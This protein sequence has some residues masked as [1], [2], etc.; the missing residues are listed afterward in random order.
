[1]RV[2]ASCIHE[3]N[4]K[5]QG[6]VMKKTNLIEPWLHI[7]LRVVY[8]WVGG[9]LEKT[10]CIKKLHCWIWKQEKVIRYFMNSESSIKHTLMEH[11]NYCLMENSMGHLWILNCPEGVNYDWWFKN[12]AI[13]W[14][15]PMVESRQ[16]NRQKNRE[17]NQGKEPHDEIPI[18]SSRR[19]LI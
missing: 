15:A 2:R 6:G 19:K 16:K 17:H 3:Q 10:N 14:N 5:T 4:A 1:M 8:Y 9:C 11:I 18:Y 13:V 7:T 12:N